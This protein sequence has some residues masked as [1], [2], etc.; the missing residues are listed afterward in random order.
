[1]RRGGKKTKL[2]KYNVSATTTTGILI[3]LNYICCT[4]IHPL[5]PIASCSIHIHGGRQKKRKE[6]RQNR[7]HDR[8][9]RRDC[10]K[11]Q[12]RRRIV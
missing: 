11:K 7:R 5:V 2:K 8:T 1:M 12:K 4:K 9:S 3:A 10:G 6:K